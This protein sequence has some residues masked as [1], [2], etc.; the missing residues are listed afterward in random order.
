MPRREKI[1]F[2]G[3]GGTIS[4][5]YSEK[6]D[7][8]TPTLSARDLV[9][10]LPENY[11]ENLQVIDWSH[12][13]SSHYTIRMTA[14][15]VE[16]LRKLVKEGVAGIVVSCG[17][18]SLEEMAYL[19]DLLWAYPQPVVFTGSMQPPGLQGSDAVANLS[20]SIRAASSECLWGMGVTACFQDQLFAASEVAK[21]VA[22]RRD[23][24]SAPGRGPVADFVGD[25]IRIIRKPNRP[26][27][28]EDSIMPAKD[29]EI[30][31]ASLGGGDWTLSCLSKSKSLEGLVLAGF[32]T[33]NIPPSWIQFLK[34]LLKNN[35]AVVI[36]TRCRRGHT[37]T[38]YG[39]EGS[40]K[41]LLEM[42][43]LDGDGLRPEHARLRLAVGLGANF[44]K[45]ELQLYLLGKK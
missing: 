3:T 26:P 7:G 27:S 25:S 31:W 4:M 38:L 40:A 23:A 45:E 14:D 20:Q 17:T 9:E 24:F 18:D 6:H 44:T 35:T 12:Q 39:F 42:G 32:G 2:V 33:G 34:P 5:T 37:T 41:R 22:H 36:T 13:P 29:V 1:A 19:T 28:F 43:V 8:Y 30:L 10:M 21:E 16:L 11:A 15:L